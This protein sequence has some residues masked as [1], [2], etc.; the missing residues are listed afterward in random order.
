MGCACG[1]LS[2]VY[3]AVGTIYTVARDF[4]PW[5]WFEPGV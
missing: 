5:N 1:T 4:N 3:S 2:K